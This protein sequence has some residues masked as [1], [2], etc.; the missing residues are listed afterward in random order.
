MF[1]LE[2]QTVPQNRLEGVP[3]C[4]FDDCTFKTTKLAVNKH[5]IK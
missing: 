5:F 3:H 2:Y 4:V 1:S